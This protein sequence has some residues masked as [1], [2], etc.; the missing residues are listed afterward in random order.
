MVKDGCVT[1]IID[2][3][4]AAYMPLW[5]E[6]L[7]VS[8]S[9]CEEDEAWKMLLRNCMPGYDAAYSFWHQYHY[10]C[11]DP[12]ICGRH[13]IDEAEREARMNE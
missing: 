3:E 4:K 9:G 10:L 1:R 12:N 6:S 11:L 2:W 13:L 5:C 8:F 7:C